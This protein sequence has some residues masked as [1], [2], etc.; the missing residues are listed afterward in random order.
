MN[1]IKKIARVTGILYLIMTLV[2]PFSM[3]YVPSQ[4]IVPGDATA[5]A[6][7]IMASG[8]LLNA[9]IIGHLVILLADLGVAVLLY[10][11]LKPVSKTI[12]LA[13]E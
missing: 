3:M 10:V 2:G 9:G 8:S 7:N 6:N 4:L 12:A 1:S 13:E 5:T 11:L